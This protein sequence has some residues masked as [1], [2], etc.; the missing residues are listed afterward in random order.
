MDSHLWTGD[1][2]KEGL[3]G[4][5]GVMLTQRGRCSLNRCAATATGPGRPQRWVLP[6]GLLGSSTA[7][8]AGDMAA[9]HANLKEGGDFTGNLDTDGLLQVVHALIKGVFKAS[10]S[11]LQASEPQTE[12]FVSLA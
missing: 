4:E 8:A 2:G 7:G 3:A 12:I 5:C 9:S 6:V 10:N 11:A 1:Q